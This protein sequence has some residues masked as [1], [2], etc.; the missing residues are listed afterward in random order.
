MAAQR[1]FSLVAVVQTE[2]PAHC[3]KRTRIRLP[4]QR[5]TLRRSQQRAL[6]YA[7]TSA[8]RV[9]AAKRDAQGS[10]ALP[11]SVRDRQLTRLPSDNVLAARAPGNAH[12]SSPSRDPVSAL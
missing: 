9:S 2:A 3:E 8:R 11:A 5:Q 7:S 4:W 1:C 6:D 10:D 12:K